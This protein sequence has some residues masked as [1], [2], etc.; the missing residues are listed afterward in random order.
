MGEDFCR[1]LY[2]FENQYSANKALWWYTRE[3]F[4]Y[5]MLNKA[6][7]VQ[8]IEVLFLFRFVIVD[9]YQQLKENQCQSSVRVYRGQVLLH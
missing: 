9:I 5:K 8:N 2:E 7:R 3:S 6:L 1:L 4:L